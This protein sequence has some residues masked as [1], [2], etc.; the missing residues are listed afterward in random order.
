MIS[1][2]ASLLTSYYAAKNGTGAAAPSSGG[3]SALADA[4]KTYSPTGASIAPKSPWAYGT[5]GMADETELTKKVLGGHRFIDSNNVLSNIAGASPDYTKLFTLYQGLSALEGVATKAQDDKTSDLQMAALRRRFSDGMKEVQSYLTDTKYDH[6]NL[7]EGT[8]STELKTADGTARTNSVYTGPMI[9][10]GLATTAVKAFEGDVR[11]SMSVKKIGT[12]TP[13]AVNIDL[14]DMGTQT[15]SMSNVVSFINTK[16]KEQGLQTKFIVNRTAAVPQT[17]TVNGKTVTLSKGLDSFGLKIQGVSTEAVTMGAPVTADSVTIVQTTGDPD[18]KTV[19]KGDDGKPKKDAAGKPVTEKGADVS[20][21]LVKFQTDVGGTLATP[22]S[23]VGDKFYAPGET[24]QTD[25]PDAVQ[26]VRQ[27]V[28][29]PDGSVYVLADVQGAINDQDTKGTQDVALIKYDSAGKVVFTRTLGA[30]ETASGYAMSVSSDGRVAIAG[31]VT[32]ALNISETAT[33]TYGTGTHTITTTTTTPTSLNGVSNAVSDSFVTVFDAHGT[34]EWTQRRG[35][36]A[37]DEATSVTF[38]DDGSVYV[39]GKTKSLM[40]GA[41]G[42]A[43]GGYDGYVMGFSTTGKAQ[44]TVQTGTA[45]TDAT[46]QVV[47]SGSTL[48]A[49]SVEDGNAVVRSY[50]LGSHDVTKTTTDSGGATHST[51]STVYTATTTGT[52]NL[53]GIG[54]GAISGISL[55]NGKLY[56]G[57]SSGSD[58]LLK[59]TGDVTKTY[60]GGYDAFALSLG[61]DLS[62]TSNDTI[63]YYG[64]TGVEKDA[65]V[66]FSDGKAWISG[67]TNAAIDGTTASSTKTGTKDAYLAR[68]NINTGAVEY[69]TRYAGQD[70]VVSPNAIAVSKGGASVLDRLGL[71]QGTIQQKDLAYGSNGKPEDTARIVSSTSVRTGDQFYLVDSSGGK[72]TITIDANDTMES[73]AKKIVRASGYRLTVDVNKMTGKSLSQLDIKTATKSTKMEFVAGPSGKDALESLGL[74]AGVISA[75]ANKV[76]D[77]SSSGYLTS[78]KGLGLEFDGAL[79]LGTDA[80]VKH[81]L[82]SLKKVMKNVQLAYNYLKYGDPQP[83]DAKKKGNSSGTVPSYLTNQ[84]ANYQAALNR[85]TGGA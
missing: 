69:Q 71:P 20:T 25:L 53:G 80:N 34:E 11:F 23:K 21:Q 35:A 78:K 66:Q 73:L 3:A 6:I 64:G 18:K 74:K 52:R 24:D 8:L 4:T 72:K 60:S 43:A 57:G 82:S 84:I 1:F 10:S 79:N 50:Q 30:S 62:D 68:L 39:G 5:T 22:I 45:N 59:T 14:A 47:V 65:K 42:S 9:H 32:G 16:L 7:T 37:E 63:A 12:A 41:G 85:L 75:D 17:Q 77:A 76:M 55:Y 70:G 61:S 83:Q 2:D 51:T 36:N 13:F 67:S 58:N 28:A 19:V 44:F 15:R 81:A 33:K 38:G 46:A 29:G 49:A 54:G 27:T 31:S 48:Y 40:A 26:N 56:L